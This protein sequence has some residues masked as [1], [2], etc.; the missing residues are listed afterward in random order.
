MNFRRSIVLAL[1]MCATAFAQNAPRVEKTEPPNWWIGLP[2]PMLLLQGDGLSDARIT[3]SKPGVHVSR[4]ENGL[5]GKYL[6]V[7]LEVANTATPGEAILNVTANG[8][9]A[10][11]RFRL[12]RR[13]D[14]SASAG[15]NGFSPDDVIYLIMPDR[16]ADG[17]PQN[18]NDAKHPATYDRAKARAYHGGDL[19][20]IREHLPYLKDLGVTT[21]WITPVYNNNDTTG[22]DYHGYGAIDLYAVEEHLGT[23]QDYKSLVQSA[24]ALG[25]KVLLDVV[26]NH[27][28]PTHPWVE[29]P[30]QA[31]WF[32]GTKDKHVAN[33]WPFA[34]ITDPH[35]PPRLWRNIVEGWFADR[36][37]DMNTDNPWTS[38]YLRQNAMWWAQTGGLDGFRIDTFPYVDRKF[39]QD[40]HGAIHKAYPRFKTVGEVWDLDP[41]VTSYFV[42]GHTVQGIDTG[43]DTDFDFPLYDALRQVILHDAPITRIPEVLRYDFLYPHPEEL[44]TFIGNHD[45]KRFMGE[46][47]ATKEKLMLAFSLLATL[48]GIP[49]LYA[50]DEIAMPGGDDPDNRRDFP[51][52]FPGDARNAFTQQG[53]TTDEQE[54]WRHLQAMLRL[55]REHPALRQG[56]LYDISSD[57]KLYAFERDF[58]GTP[59]GLGSTNMQTERL[60]VIANN[61]DKSRSGSFEIKDTPI[62]TA[63][64]VKTIFAKS[65]ATLANG[66]IQVE[67]PARS[68]VIYEVQCGCDLR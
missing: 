24:H 56:K 23:L 12:D 45:T 67:V 9:G 13:G 63:E 44:V 35:A 52:G 43:L 6:F 46:T 21:L 2:S 65:P 30:P 4:V 41:T 8:A 62:E 25:M 22:Q 28:G 5:N 40:F 53:R 20:G 54:V 11:V 1:M 59:K 57:D 58:V 15:F 66:K 33:G 10:K 29:T 32:H 7:W 60:L 14:T 49:Q 38:Q 61:S 68:L 42:G 36:L 50:G 3:V 16:F 39:W 55:R 19:R 31:N 26:P 51:G 64:M 48:R 17:D 27:V 18:D 34:P 47:G 37:P